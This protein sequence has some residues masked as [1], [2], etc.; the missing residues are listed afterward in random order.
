MLISFIGSDYQPKYLRSSFTLKHYIMSKEKVTETKAAKLKPIPP[1]KTKFGKLEIFRDKKQLNWH[2]KARNGNI[3][4]SGKGLNTMDSV[5]KSV[6]ASFRILNA[7][8]AE[9]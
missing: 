8:M 1:I 9:L 5:K 2:L 3:L 4:C 6:S 7:L